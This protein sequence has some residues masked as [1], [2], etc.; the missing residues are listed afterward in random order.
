MQ[1]TKSDTGVAA[2]LQSVFSSQEAARYFP[3]T[4][5]H[6]EANDEDAELSSL[7]ALLFEEFIQA[8]PNSH[9]D[10]FGNY[11]FFGPLRHFIL[12]HP[13]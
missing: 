12:A 11:Y 6:E 3:G 4:A 2:K 10:A 1:Q 8:V 5:P 7:E 13:K 9:T